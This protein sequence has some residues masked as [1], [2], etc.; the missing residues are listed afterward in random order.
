MN[1]E[2]RS[3][4]LLEVDIRDLSAGIVGE[5]ILAGTPD[6]ISGILK[7]T[8]TGNLRPP[9]LLPESEASEA[10]PGILYFFEE[11]LL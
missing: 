10:C 6:D 8:G 1:H 9:D 2:A 4:H 5:I 3:S 7:K 11:Y